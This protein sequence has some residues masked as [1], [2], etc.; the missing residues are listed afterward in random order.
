M[1]GMLVDVLF[2]VQLRIDRNKKIMGGDLQ[3]MAA[4]IEKRNI[5]GSGGLSEFGNR[6]LHAR[7]IEID[8]ERDLET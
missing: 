5:G 2:A 6:A 1:H 8:A 7:L 4:I 3:A